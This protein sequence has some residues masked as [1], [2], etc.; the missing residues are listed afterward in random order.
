MSFVKRYFKSIVGLTA[1]IL[2]IVAIVF[3][4]TVNYY[5]SYEQSKSYGGD[6][7]TG[8]QNAAAQTANNV[9]QF[10]NAYIESYAYFMTFIGLT[11]I[12]GGSLSTVYNIIEVS[13]NRKKVTEN[14][15]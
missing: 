4:W 14:N 2:G 5:G 13:S 15:C 8:I 10:G 9:D 1:V 11:M 3:G 12:A 6:A 7:Y